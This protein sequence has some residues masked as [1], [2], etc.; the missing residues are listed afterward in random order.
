MESD[1]I[2]RGS[3]TDGRW[4][5]YTVRTTADSVLVT[6]NRRGDDVVLEVAGGSRAPSRNY[7]GAESNDHPHRPRRDGYKLH[8]AACGTGNSSVTISDYYYGIDIAR[9]IVNV[10]SQAEIDEED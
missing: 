9:Y 1:W 8:L 7:C 4:F 2:A 3:L 6:V 10:G 5:T